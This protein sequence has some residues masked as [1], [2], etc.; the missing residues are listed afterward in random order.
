MYFKIRE[1]EKHAKSINAIHHKN[2]NSQIFHLLVGMLHVA[3]L[4]ND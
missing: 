2:K 3:T 1:E 4:K